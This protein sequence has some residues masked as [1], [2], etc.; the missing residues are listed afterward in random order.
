MRLPRRLGH[1]EEASLVEH[2]DEFRTRLIIS[3]IALSIGF[4]VAFAF[5]A[6]LIHWLN[7]AL[8]A[9]QRKPVTFGVT[10][11]FFTS[12]KVSLYAGFALALPVILYQLWS[13]FAPA[14][15]EHAQRT[16]A[17]FVT[18]AS[19]LFAAGLAFAYW[20]VLPAGVSF[21]V[22]YDKE[23]YT[24]QVRASYYYS[25]AALLLVAIALIFELP[26]F[27]LALVRLGV[28]TTAKLRRNRRIGYL[29]MF[30]IAVLLPTVDPVSLVFETIPLL[31]L[32]EGSIWLSVVMERRWHR[33]SDAELATG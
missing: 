2:L 12:V 9:D 10:E 32:Y 21:L 11:P 22:N 20:V 24:I 33:S 1:G 19:G 4:V 3:L 28:L 15:E 13:F 17:V 14:I 26:I 8:P 6:H 31:I 25:F 30:I 29:V 18:L 27:V 5:H 16:V 7:Q 23:L